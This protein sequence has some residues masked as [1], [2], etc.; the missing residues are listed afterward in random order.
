MT[1]GGLLVRTAAGL[2]LAAGVLAGKAAAAADYPAPKEGD[3]IAQDL[4]FD[5]DR[6]GM[7]RLPNLESVP[8]R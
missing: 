7:Q 8:L 1:V 6:P 3:W 2:M 5:A 4:K